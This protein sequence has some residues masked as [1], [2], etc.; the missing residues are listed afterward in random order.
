ML[1][2]WERRTISL[3]GIILLTPFFLLFLLLASCD[4][5]S[6]E[7][8]PVSEGDGPINLTQMEE[9]LISLIEEHGN[10]TDLVVRLALVYYYDGRLEKVGVLLKERGNMSDPLTLYLYGS[11][12]LKK[13]QYDEA[14]EQFN[15]SMAFG[16]TLPYA[17]FGMGR[18]MQETGR[19]DSAE[20]YYLKSLEMNATR[21]ISYKALGTIYASRGEWEKA[22]NMH[23]RAIGIK[24]DCYGSYAE[25][26]KIY[27]HRGD[28]ERAEEMFRKSI[29]INEYYYIAYGGLASLFESKGDMEQAESFFKKAIEAKPYV[30]NS[31]ADLGRFYE[32]RDRMPEAIAEFEKALELNPDNVPIRQ[33]LDALREKLP[34]V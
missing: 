10:T 18:I 22:E 6:K 14:A 13:Y 31:H 25:L 2:Q 5:A 23:K 26:G 11:Y 24:P 34:S 1:K 21:A 32:R 20:E 30:S 3:N 8:P 29:E 19:V 4:S 33:K 9:D 7:V 27:M 28:L 17:Y 15:K 16:D 12:F